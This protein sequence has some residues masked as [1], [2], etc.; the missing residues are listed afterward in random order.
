MP[1]RRN[2]LKQTGAALGYSSLLHSGIPLFAQNSLANQNLSSSVY[3]G[4]ASLAARA[5]RTRL[6]YGCAVVP[7]RLNM[8]MQYTRTI[9]EQCSILVAENAMKW[10]AI[11]PQ[12]NAFNFAGADKLLAFAQAHNM[13]VR[14]H[15]LSWH[16][17]LPPWFKMTVNRENAQAILVQHIQTVAGRYAGKLHSWD[18]VNEAIRVRDGRSD[19][20]RT[21]PWLELI[22]ENYIDIAFRTARQADLH[23]LLTYNDYGIEYDS[24]NEERKRAAVLALLRGM[25]KRKTPI[26]AVGIQSHLHAGSQADFGRGLKHFLHEVRKL[27]LQ[28]FITEMDVDDSKLTTDAEQR[29]VAVAAIYQK[30]FDLMLRDPQVT[31]ALT[32][33]ITNRYTW[34]SHIHPRKDGGQSIALPFDTNYQP[35]KAFFA[36]GIAFDRR[37]VQSVAPAL[38]AKVS[39]SSAIHVPA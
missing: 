15:N 7:E 8:D 11:H 25:R 36:M 32:W 17:A 31:A 13:Q 10:A 4:A 6:P 38:P 22:G 9:I 18:V 30:Y 35:S 29:E 3:T 14:G 23:A 2:F 20:L 33:G 27:D 37:K 1:T 12:P 16:Q 34:L 39:N 24:P 19:G 26:D 28:V 21:T 5:A